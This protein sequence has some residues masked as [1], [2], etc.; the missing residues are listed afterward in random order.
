MPISESHPVICENLDKRGKLCGLFARTIEDR[1]ILFG[2]SSG[3]QP[4]PAPTFA[5]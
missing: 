1:L 4:E 5:R 3:W 2:F